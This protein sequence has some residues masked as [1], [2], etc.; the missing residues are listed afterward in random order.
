MHILKRKC[1]PGQIDV[2]GFFILCPSCGVG[3]PHQ[4]VK[5]EPQG[6]DGSNPSLGTYRVVTKLVKC[7]PWKEEI[8]GS[9]PAYSTV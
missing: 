6:F 2:Q 1:S 5:L 4:S 8:A 7:F 3:D 9:S